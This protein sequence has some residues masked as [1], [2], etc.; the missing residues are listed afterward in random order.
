MT[1]EQRLNRIKNAFH[2]YRE[3]GWKLPVYM[4]MH[5]IF[6]LSPYSNTHDLMENGENRS[7][8]GDVASHYNNIFNTSDAARRH[9]DAVYNEFLDTMYQ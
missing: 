9:R 7:T 5:D 6:P 1:F 3:H 4:Q 8:Y 2:A